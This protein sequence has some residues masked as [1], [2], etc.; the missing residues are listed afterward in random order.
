MPF[1]S[2]AQRRKLWAINPEL[3]R[4][5]EAETPKGANLPERVKA[6]KKHPDR[7]RR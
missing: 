6:K 4:R 2:A 5:W 1:R 7:R 3:A